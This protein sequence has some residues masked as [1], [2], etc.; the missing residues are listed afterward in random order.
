LG[1][2]SRVFFGHLW[3]Q[4]WG[5]APNRGFGGECEAGEREFSYRSLHGLAAWRVVFPERQASAGLAHAAINC[6]DGKC[7][8]LRSHV[9]HTSYPNR[10]N[11]TT[12][13]VPYGNP[14]A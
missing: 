3:E 9:Q 6:V 4:A 14:V 13:L 11:R 2:R 5:G 1:G 7:H 8:E 12:V 10:T